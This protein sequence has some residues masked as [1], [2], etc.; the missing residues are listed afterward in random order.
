MSIPSALQSL[1]DR[2]LRIIDRV[3]A[4]APLLI[5]L[6]VGLVF[7]STGWASCTASRMSPLSFK[8]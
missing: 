1:R 6:T 8:R 4:V 2:G 7:I 3:S 5:R